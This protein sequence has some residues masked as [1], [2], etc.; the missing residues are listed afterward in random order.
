MSLFL[1]LPIA[2]WP[3]F[4]SVVLG[5]QLLILGGR[6]SSLVPWFYSFFGE[7]AMGSESFWS[8]IQNSMLKD[9]MIYFL[10]RA[11]V[12]TYFWSMYWKMVILRCFQ[13]SCFAFLICPISLFEE[14]YTRIMG[15]NWPLYINKNWK[16]FVNNNKK[17]KLRS[18][19]TI[20][21]WGAGNARAPLEHLWNLGFQKRGEAWFLLIGV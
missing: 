13:N 11:W 9:L 18:D 3:L 19:S 12:S 1:N 14:I 5:F 2:F 4:A 8:F 21:S 16:P 6:H 17:T 7:Y 10:F 15:L 20:D